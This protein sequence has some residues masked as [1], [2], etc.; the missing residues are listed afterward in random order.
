MSSRRIFGFRFCLAVTILCIL[1]MLAASVPHPITQVSAQEVGGTIAIHSDGNGNSSSSGI[2]GHSW[3]EYTPDGG[4]TT[5]YGTWGTGTVENPGVNENLE[6]DWDSEASRT[7]HVNEAQE[8]ALMDYIDSQKALGPDAHT[9]LHNCSSFA[10]E[11]WEVATG[12][13][14]SPGWIPNPT[15][16]RENIKVANGG[17][18]HGSVGGGTDGGIE[19]QPLSPTFDTTFL[20]KAASRS[21]PLFTVEGI[22]PSE[23]PE[24]TTPVPVTP[25]DVL[26]YTNAVE[27]HAVDFRRDPADKDTTVA[28]ALVT[29]TLGETYW[30]DH[31]VCA[32]FH[33]YTLDALMPIS[34]PGL[35]GASSEGEGPWF[36]YGLAH[37]DTILEEA[38]VFSVFVNEAQQEFVVDSH[39]VRTEYACHWRDSEPFNYI[40]NYQIW[41]SSGLETY[42]L[43]QRVF[44]KLSEIGPGWTI[45][46][47]NDTEPI[48]P[49]VVM[50]SADLIGH[51]VSI[52]VKS[53]LSEPRL[54]LFHGTKQMCLGC[55]DIPFEYWEAVNPGLNFINLPVGNI[56]NTVVYSEAD[57]FLDK[58]YTEREVITPQV[59]HLSVRKLSGALR[60]PPALGFSTPSQGRSP[61]SRTR[62]KAF[63]DDLLVYLPV[64]VHGWPAPSINIVWPPDGAFVLVEQDLTGEADDYRLTIHGTVQE[65]KP[66]WT[67]FVEVLTDI[68]YPQGA[69]TVRS[70][71]WGARVHLAGQGGY[72]N[73][74]I[75]VTLQDES[76][77]AV[78]TAMV[79]DIVRMNPCEAP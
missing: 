47:T 50:T 40:L 48:S 52:T 67:I 64:V 10:S 25:H 38:L 9:L 39:W 41:S 56:S 53:W 24:G 15:T 59:T 62:A 17:Q 26:G 16:L 21:Q 71:L 54:V 1:G 63:S 28:V 23:G 44:E 60:E 77:A 76:G 33:R 34:L 6:L 4:E 12:E 30:H 70:G 32:R 78:A 19:S 18:P 37:R 69:A 66:D 29:K 73:H 14:I 5:T 20:T 42:K 43:L 22:L 27:A 36:W 79:N 35:A 46:F 58:I 65:M 72:N 74:K 61:P 68:W 8:Q 2:S 49:T 31:S 13:H 55:A 51:T 75:R 3:V 11:A 45:T 7:A 57:G